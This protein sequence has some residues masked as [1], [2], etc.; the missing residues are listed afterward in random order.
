MSAESNNIILGVKD[1]VAGYGKKQILNGIS[2]EV[3]TAEI[4]TLIGHN[5]AG[6][7]TLLKAVFGIIPMWRGQFSFEGKTILSPNPREL[8]LQGIAYVPQGNRVFTDLTVK[9]NIEVAGNTLPSKNE[10]SEGMEKALAWFPSLRELFNQRAGTLSGG[11]KQM[12]ALASGLVTSPR[13]LLLDEPSL[14]LAPP[15]V[16][17]ALEH[18]KTIS[19]EQ[20]VT[21]LI[22]EQ[23]V[24]EVLK[25]A[26]RVYVLRNG[27]VSFTGLASDLQD[28]AKLREVYL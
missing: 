17:E 24:R 14:G 27:S 7:S 15:L 9:E 1:L 11:E 26:N 12:L 5:G 13:L 2:L 20:G 22:V 25:I 16:S 4:V 10:R 28:E 18:I 3:A 21:V 23:K 8:L 6:K 19:Q